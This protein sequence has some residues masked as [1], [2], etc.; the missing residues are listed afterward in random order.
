MNATVDTVPAPAPAPAPGSIWRT[1]ALLCKQHDASLYLFAVS[2]SGKPQTAKFTLA[3]KGKVE[4]EVQ[5]E[6]RKLAASGGRFA[7]EFAPYA[8]HIYRLPK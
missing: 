2:M 1:L 5:G 3:T 6:K 8:V 4:V 7:D